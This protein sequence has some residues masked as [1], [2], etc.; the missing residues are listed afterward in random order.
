LIGELF[1]CLAKYH[2][3]GKVSAVTESALQKIVTNEGFLPDD[4]VASQAFNAE[5]L[6]DLLVKIRCP[7]MS[8]MLEDKPRFN[9]L[10]SYRT[11]MVNHPEGAVPMPKSSYRNNGFFQNRK[12]TNTNRTT[13][14]KPQTAEEPNTSK[15]QTAEGQKEKN[16]QVQPQKTPVKEIKIN[17][18]KITDFDSF[19]RE[20]FGKVD[21][22]VVSLD[23][24]AVGI[25][26]EKEKEKLSE[27]LKKFFD[28]PP[29]SKEEAEKLFE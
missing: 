9:E 14:A 8:A 13:A 27:K 24:E 28:S 11:H 29:N 2:V 6:S 18:V 17:G 23:G 3:S 15:S 25:F 16:V 1:I 12:T 19:I 5:S 10:P 21:N 22:Y 7:A 26:E 4:R 20:D